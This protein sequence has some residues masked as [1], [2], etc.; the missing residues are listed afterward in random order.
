MS[1]LINM[2]EVIINNRNKNNHNIEEYRFQ[3]VQ[4]MYP[5]IQDKINLLVFLTEINRD[6]FQAQTDKVSEHIV[7]VLHKYQAIMA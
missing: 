3:L 1:I 4:H 2:Q 7:V 6:Q 5:L